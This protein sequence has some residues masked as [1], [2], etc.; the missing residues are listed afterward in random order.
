[1]CLST[2][3]ENYEDVVTTLAELKMDADAKCS[4]TASIAQSGYG[5]I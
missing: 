5:D 2:I 4:S 3:I 1:M